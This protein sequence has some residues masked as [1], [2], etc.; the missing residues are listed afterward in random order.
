MINYAL[1]LFCIAS[2]EVNSVD[3]VAVTEE[4]ILVLFSHLD[5][6]KKIPA[7]CNGGYN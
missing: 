6:I 1:S 4:E 5:G 7:E 3:I 2:T